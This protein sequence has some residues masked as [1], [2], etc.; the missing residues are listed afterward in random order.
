MVYPSTTLHEVRPVLSGERLVGLTFI[1]STIQD[2]GLRELLYNLDEV[3]ALEGLQMQWGEPHPP[4]LR[5][6]QPAPDV[7]RVRLASAR[8]RGGGRAHGVCE[9]GM[10]RRRPRSARR[11]PAR[12]RR[13]GLGARLGEDAPAQAGVIGEL[14]RLGIAG[15]VGASAAW[16]RR[17]PPARPR[18]AGAGSP[19]GPRP[20]ASRNASNPATARRWGEAAAMAARAVI[21]HSQA[22]AAISPSD[23]R[24]S[25]QASRPSRRCR[26]ASRMGALIRASSRE[27]SPERMPAR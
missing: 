13:R 12:S 22:A 9:D 27:A 18:A 2:P 25:R 3:A 4:R 26:R 6:Q 14:R 7:E 10:G 1:E 16:R 15:E 20:G 23:I 11:S 5:P 21:S 24:S 17:P 19:P 8:P